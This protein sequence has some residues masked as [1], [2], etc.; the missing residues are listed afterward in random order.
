MSSSPITS[1]QIERF[2]VETVTSFIFLRFKIIVD[3]D[4]SHE[5]ER[6]LLLGRKAMT[7]LHNVLKIGD[8]TLPI[9]V[10]I[11]KAMVFPVVMYRYDSW[12]IKKAECLRIDA[13]ELW[14][15]RRLLRVPGN[16]EIKPVD[17][18]GNQPWIFIGKTDAEA[19]TLILQ[20]SD[21]RS[22]LI[23]KDLDA[24]KT[25]GRRT[26]GWQRMRWLDGISDWM[27][28]NLSKL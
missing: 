13:F 17:P 2:K 18:K 22:W 27:D 20:S 1:W 19:K 10:H 7:N 4:C 28:M 26:R 6:C 23:G 12:I 8:I 3:D 25:E 9:K 5:T 14:C 24:G 11:V 21:E 15:W 16:K